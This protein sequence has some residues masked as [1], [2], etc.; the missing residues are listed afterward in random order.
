MVYQYIDT[1]LRRSFTTERGDSH[2]LFDVRFRSTRDLDRSRYISRFIVHMSQICLRTGCF[3]TSFEKLLEIKIR[4][5]LPLLFLSRQNRISTV[6]ER[7]IN[8]FSLELMLKVQLNKRFSTHSSLRFFRA[9]DKSGIVIER[10]STSFRLKIM[11]E[12]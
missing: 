3:E 6:I 9:Y 5:E 7:F 11:L 8:E 2:R 4:N 12:I 10:L 1:L